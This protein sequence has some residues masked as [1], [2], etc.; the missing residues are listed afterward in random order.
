MKFNYADERTQS[1]NL[2]AER[3][4]AERRALAAS[5]PKGLGESGQLLRLAGVLIGPGC[6][7]KISPFMNGDDGVVEAGYLAEIAGDLLA[8]SIQLLDAGHHYSVAA[9]VRQLVEVEY[10]MWLFA[11]KPNVPGDWLRSDRKTRRDQWQPRHLR[12][13][14]DGRFDA[15]DYKHHCELGGH[16]TPD[17][18]R[19]FIDTAVSKRVVV[20][21]LL[22]FEMCEHGANIWGAF[23]E[24]AGR[25]QINLPVSATLDPM[26]GNWRTVDGL[27]GSARK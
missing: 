20:A 18:A 17:G 8:S 19:I 10:L 24:V 22:L 23:K 21:E 26:I 11:N 9:L 16:P 14:S 15:D 6:A 2:A 3:G 1:V 13:R 27:I 4:R 25:A 7:E 12:D 5:L